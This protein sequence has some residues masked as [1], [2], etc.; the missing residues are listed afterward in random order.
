MFSTALVAVQKYTLPVIYSR[1][2]VSGKVNSGCGTFLIVNR[3]GWILTAGHV[4][5]E[6]QTIVQHQAELNAYEQQ[7]DAILQTPNLTGKQKNKQIA[8]LQRNPDWIKNQATMWAGFARAQLVTASVDQVADLGVGRLEPFDPA[9]VQGYPVFKNPAEPMLVGTSLCRLGYPL[10]Q[11]EATFDD[12]TGQFTLAPGVLPVPRF[13]NDGIYTRD[14]IMNSPDGQR[15]AKLIETSTPGLRGQSGGPIF[16][17]NGHVWAIQSRTQS[18]PLGF[19]PTVK[20][21][22]KEIVEH[23]FIHVGW[24]THV[25]EAIR[26]MRDHNIAF[27]TSTP[28]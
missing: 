25:A 19:T 2:T 28:L 3:D 8:R 24:G 14:V 18:L 5:M 20:I 10:H 7:R 4:L 11:I 1:R 17:R 22:N 12:Q 27:E 26:M 21:G 15:Q 13:P 9:W 6:L 23:Q 16:D